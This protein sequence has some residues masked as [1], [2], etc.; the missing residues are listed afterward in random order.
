MPAIDLARLKK[1]VVRLADSFDRPQAFL[2]ELH[3]ILDFYVNRTLRTRQAVAPASVLETYRTPTLVLRHIEKELA[4]LA[5]A[6]PNQALELADALWEARYLETRLLAAFLIG[7]I[8]PQEDRLLV[9]LT[10]WSQQIRD[11]SVRAAL[12]TTGLARLRSEAPDRLLLLVSEWLHPSRPSFWSNGIQALLP[13]LRETKYENLPPIFESVAP[14][15][16]AAPAI[17][18]DD[19]KQI[20]QALYQASPVETTYFLKKLIQESPNPQTKIVLRRILPDLPLELQEKIRDL[21]RQPRI[22]E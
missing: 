19:I 7:R 11:P 21:V 1:Q 3:T 12:L 18:Q 6:N 17:L 5:E 9:H 22:T 8:P 4:P 16:Q 2:Q 13:L 20:L 10:V 15:I 14:V